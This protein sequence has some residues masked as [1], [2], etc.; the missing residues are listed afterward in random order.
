M[1]VAGSSRPAETESIMNNIRITT[2][3]FILGLALSVPAFSQDA[4][5][6][7]APS[8]AVRYNYVGDDV[9]IGIGYNSD[10]K[11]TGEFFWAFDEEPDSAWVAEGWL[12]DESSGGLKMNFH[13]LSGGVEAGIGADGRP[14]YSDGR[15]RKLFLAAD[16]N[17]FD[18]SKM[19]LGFGSERQDRF[20]SLTASRSTSGERFIGQVVDV[21]EMLVTGI[22][23]N[24]AFSRLDTWE[25]ITDMFAHP[26]EWGVGFRVG[27]Y[28][29]DALVR[30]RGGLD[31]ESGD[32][33]SSQL[34]A[35]ASLDKR[36]EN[37]EHG[38]SLRAEALHKQGDFETDQDDFRITA[39]WTWDFGRSFS[40]AN[41]F[42]DVQV[43]RIPDPSELAREKV[44]EVITN[45]VTLDDTASFDLDSHA[46]KDDARAAL[47]KVLSSLASAEL[48]SD[49]TV[50]G[51]TCS[52][53]SD[54]YNQALSERR[55]RSVYDFLVANGVDPGI[56]RW[57][58]RGEREPR[59]SNET[60]ESRSRNRRVEISFVAK[61]EIVREV[62]VGEGQP[63]TEWVQERVPVEAAWIR[64]ALRNPVAHK[65]SVDYYRFNR[66]TERHTTGETVI[67]NTGPTARNDSYVIDQDSADNSLDVLVNDSDPEGDALVV[68]L[69]T[70]PQNG[71]V[72]ISGNAVLYTPNPG[73]YG[74]DSF[75]YT[76]EDGYGGVDS[77]TVNITIDPANGPPLAADDQFIV[78]MD[79]SGNLLTVLGNDTDPEGDSF[80]LV[81]VSTP[82]HGTASISGDRIS[83]TPN[84]G[85][86]GSDQFTYTIQD[87]FGRQSTATV[88]VTV[89]ETNLPPVAVDD[90]A[91]TK[92]D[93]SVVIDVLANDSDPNGDPLTIIQIIQPENKMG[94]VEINGDGTVTYIPMPNWWGGDTFQYVISDGRGGTATATVTLDVTQI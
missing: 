66:V 74:A 65:R 55:A 68:T 27:R 70:A 16:R 64:R 75:S 3:G 49:I 84:P 51:H 59:Y 81:A 72:S 19:S 22:A 91:F 88:L 30:L 85:F 78:S 69:V 87:G 11:L 43:E 32:Y 94:T 17:V 35:F 61:E 5:E 7:P 82:A 12:G 89:D 40:P 44:V 46:L 63:V 53:A 24:H 86:F 10:T 90:L 60:E 31:Y 56:I 4:G 47:R 15:V 25:T 92:K 50:I 29:E 2:S 26:Y 8:D 39:M 1:W 37:S 36:F 54:E 48:A 13:W 45:Q 58:G 80:T 62:L 67:E 18:D 20:W 28:F 34:T 21:Q 33:D 23:G 79:S 83:Y 93:T 76:I 9:R 42:R 73:Y 52:L 6:T 38:L 41:V 57:E 14:V 71:T 77:A